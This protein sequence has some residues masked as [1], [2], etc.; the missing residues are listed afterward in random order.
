MFPV[1]YVAR[2]RTIHQ[3]VKNE[4]AFEERRAGGKREASLV[5]KDG[6]ILRA[7]EDL[8]SFSIPVIYK[9]CDIV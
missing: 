2:R 9:V 4:Q 5:G 7:A 6:G 1:S 3:E 8:V